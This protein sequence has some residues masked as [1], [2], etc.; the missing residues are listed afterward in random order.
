[1]SSRSKQLPNHWSLARQH[2]VIYL[3][4]GSAMGIGN[5]VIF[6]SLLARY[7]ILSVFFLHLM[8]LLVFSLPLMLAEM[9]WS[10]WLQR[11]L[12]ES[13][14][15][16]GI[17]GALIWP[18]IV[19]AWIDVTPGY[20]IELGRLIS[21]LVEPWWAFQDRLATW[22]GGSV[23]AA[24]SLVSYGMAMI[25]M[26]VSL[27]FCVLPKRRL[28]RLFR[29]LCFGVLAS[30]LILIGGIL[31]GTTWSG[32]Y[33]GVFA[34]EFRRLNEG[35]LLEIFTYSLFTLSAAL[36][37]HYTF[38]F[39]GS[40]KA[41]SPRSREGF[42]KSPGSLLRL[43]AWVTLGDVI[44]SILAALLLVSYLG[45]NLYLG[46]EHDF[47]HP[48]FFVLHAFPQILLRLKA[49]FFFYSLYLFLLLAAGFMALLSLIDVALLTI[50]KE[51]KMHRW[52][53]ALLVG[54]LLALL[55]AAPLI[56]VV[57]EWVSDFGQ[58]FLLP[59]AAL[60]WSLVAGWGMPRRA[61]ASLIG[62]G[63]ILDGILL[64]WRFIVRWLLPSVL[65]YLLIVRIFG[66]RS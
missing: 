37:I 36:G 62:R 2:Q 63:P 13:F 42:W 53:A 44:F 45:S 39:Y 35:A 8:M 9:I 43:A 1:M 64:L 56:P 19:L 49:G 55:S 18:I 61:Q 48:E 17:I 41:S 32:D 23:S 60:L 52:G 22:I 3:A 10:R 57:R 38:V 14:R 51:L 40:Q 11:S 31:A 21:E 26:A 16:I 12:A 54:F 24:R 5:L 30:A 4:L 28:V 58:G 46:S 65:F 34:L 50:E 29:I 25:L 59:I 27:M 66:L 20:L 47:S 15:S 33:S 7:G 6:P